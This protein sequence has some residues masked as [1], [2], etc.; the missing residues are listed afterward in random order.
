MIREEPREFGIAMVAQPLPW[1]CLGEF[2]WEE[3]GP[4]PPL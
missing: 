1:A 4:L 2:P 3:E